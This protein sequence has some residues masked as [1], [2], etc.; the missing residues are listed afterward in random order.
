MRKSKRGEKRSGKNYEREKSKER[1]ISKW[2]KIRGY[3]WIN[4]TGQDRIYVS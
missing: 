1:K 2:K 3:N 4:G